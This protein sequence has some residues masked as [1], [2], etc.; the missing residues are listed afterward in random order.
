MGKRLHEITKKMHFFEKIFA[1]TLD[2]GKK[3]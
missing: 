2:R 1:K 3:V